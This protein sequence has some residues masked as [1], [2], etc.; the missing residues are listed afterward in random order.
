[1]TSANSTSAVDV[2]TTE[3]IRNFFQS[4]AED[5]NAVLIRSAYSPIIYEVRDCSVVLLD[6]NGD[7]LG[8]NNG[9]PIF[10]GNLEFCVKYAIDALGKDS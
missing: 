4:C 5:M 8:M 2:V 9:L 3:V 6:A 7:M 10:L 1:M